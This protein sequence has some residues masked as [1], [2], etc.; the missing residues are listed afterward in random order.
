[1]FNILLDCLPEE[2]QGYPIDSDFQT[3]IQITQVLEDTELTE[4]ERTNTAIALLFPSSAPDYKTAVEGVTWFLSGWYTDK[5]AKKEEERKKLTDYDVDGWRIYSAFRAQYG[6]N[7][8]RDKLHYW[9]FI[10]L[11][12]TLEECAYTR[13]IEI[14]RKKV[15][16]KMSAQEKNALK[17]AKAIYELEQ[18]EEQM[19]PEELREQEIFLAAVK[20]KK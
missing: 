19:T 13:I 4:W 3:G 20:G 11:L 8:N 18:P 5:H 15:N 17:E 9:E 6:I 16:S 7:L 14:R 10:T 2:Y 12:S 1:M